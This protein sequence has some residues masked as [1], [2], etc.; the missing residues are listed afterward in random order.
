MTN[1]PKLLYFV[2]KRQKCAILC[3]Q[4]VYNVKFT[5]RK[6]YTDKIRLPTSGLSNIANEPV[7]PVS[8]SRY[9]W[10]NIALYAYPPDL[11]TP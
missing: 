11:V 3:V 9:T 1:H 4:F 10:P 2:M 7:C 6:S 8:T 5:H